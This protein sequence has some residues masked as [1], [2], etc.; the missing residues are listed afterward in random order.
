M[1]SCHQASLNNAFR[2]FWQKPAG[3]SKTR[4][5]RRYS[6][7]VVEWSSVYNRLGMS[8]F[9]WLS[10][11]Y[12]FC[13]TMLHFLRG[14]EFHNGATL[15]VSLPVLLLDSPVCGICHLVAD[16]TCCLSSSSAGVEI[17]PEWQAASS[18]ILTYNRKI[19]SAFWQKPAGRKEHGCIC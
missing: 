2:W 18:P 6:Y 16:T 14:K 17:L 9:D 5:D 4:T 1:D 11:N 15:P 19:W 13:C 3:G 12:T 7:S 10:G 8:H